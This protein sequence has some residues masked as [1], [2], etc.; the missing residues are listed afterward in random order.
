MPYVYIETWPE[1]KHVRNIVYISWYMFL[2]LSIIKIYVEQ[3]Q[4]EYVVANIQYIHIKFSLKLSF[5]IPD[6]K[7]KII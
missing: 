7:Q 5:L 1:T 3:A 4:V 6:I 2:K